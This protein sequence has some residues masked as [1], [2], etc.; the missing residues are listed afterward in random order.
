MRVVVD[1]P[2]GLVCD[3]Y[4]IIIV[5]YGEVPLDPNRKKWVSRVRCKEH[6]PSGRKLNSVGV[7]ASYLERGRRN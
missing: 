2:L 3:L 7:V 6:N 4:A 5:I 1:I